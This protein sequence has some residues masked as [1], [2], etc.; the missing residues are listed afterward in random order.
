VGAIGGWIEAYHLDPAIH[1]T[2]VLTR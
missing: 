2:S 1:Y